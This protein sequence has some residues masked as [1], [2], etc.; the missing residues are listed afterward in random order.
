MGIFVAGLIWQA[1]GQANEVKAMK[2]QLE[3]KIEWTEKTNAATA[4]AI[5]EIKDDLKELRKTVESWK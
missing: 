2:T 5:K 4:A 1:A 3:M